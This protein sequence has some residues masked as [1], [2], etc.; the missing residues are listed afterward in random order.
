[1]VGAN[2]LSNLKGVE[3]TP[4][5]VS[6]ECFDEFSELTAN[7][8]NENRWSAAEELMATMEGVLMERDELE[9]E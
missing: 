8:S 6:Q 7:M 4:Q 9:R 2:V 1:M 5:E 3:M